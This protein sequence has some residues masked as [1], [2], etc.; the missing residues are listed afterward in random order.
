MARF[1]LLILIFG[2]CR[3]GIGQDFTGQVFIVAEEFLEEECRVVAE[4][5]CC[6]TELFFLP[7]TKFGFVS[8]CLSGDTYFTGT[9]SLAS[10][11]LVLKFMSV[12]VDEIVDDDYKVIKYETRQQNMDAIEFEI[13]Q[14][15]Q[16]IRLTHPTTR[17]W[18]NASR[19]PES[20]EK[21]KL[22]KL[23]TSKPWKQ[24]SR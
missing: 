8:R 3:T 12:Y 1:T 17:D 6:A 5:D 4:C 11:R 2:L 13:K 23:L 9:Y 16:R 19:Y 15:G 24:L 14:C 18:K 21:M 22:H 7:G 10:S 20:A